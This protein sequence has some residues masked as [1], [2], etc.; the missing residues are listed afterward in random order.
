[1]IHIP[2]TPHTTVDLTLLWESFNPPG[3]S[4]RMATF[5]WGDVHVKTKVRVVVKYGT[6][7]ELGQ[8]V[9]LANHREPYRH[10]A[11]NSL[12]SNGIGQRLLPGECEQAPRLLWSWQT[13]NS[14]HTINLAHAIQCT[15]TVQWTVD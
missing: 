10:V 6:C 14:I 12:S 5:V 4:L 1:M 2:H 9:L 8:P 7:D 13:M 11:S 15:E 3:S